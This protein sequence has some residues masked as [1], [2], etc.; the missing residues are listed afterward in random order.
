MGSPANF[1]QNLKK[2]K[3]L[4]EK[5]K[6]GCYFKAGTP[7]CL[8]RLLLGDCPAAT[9]SECRKTAERHEAKGIVE[10]PPQD[11]IKKIEIWGKVFEPAYDYRVKS[12]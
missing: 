3:K 4:R 11:N 2:E 5:N 1:F 12:E 8:S 9:D 10:V 7:E 6:W